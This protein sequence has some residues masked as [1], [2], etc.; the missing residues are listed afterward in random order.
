MPSGLL[1]CPIFSFNPFPRPKFPV[2]VNRMLLQRYVLREHL[3]PFLFS[4]AVIMFL[5]IVDLILHTMDLVL[6][7]A[8]QRLVIVELFFLNTAWMVALAVPM[9]V[10]VAT[11][12]AFGRLSADNEVTAIRSAGVGGLQ[13]LWPVLAAA[14]LLALGLVWFND[15]VLPEF[16][17]RARL[18]TSDIQRKRPT[19]VLA[20]REGTVIRDF[21]NLRFVFGGTDNQ[22]SELTDL[23]IY[24]YEK[25]TFPVTIVAARGEI[26]HE[27]GSD[28]AFLALYNGEIHRF[29]DSEPEVYISATF[30]KQVLRLGDAGRRLRRTTSEYRTDREMGIGR[31]QERVAEVE[32]ELLAMHASAGDRI[33]A[34][35]RPLLL[36]EPVAKVQRQTVQF[37]S[38]ARSD[39]TLSRHKK[40]YADRYRVEIHKKYSIPAACIAFVLVGVPLGV[41]VRGSG[42]GIGTG[43]SIG[44]FLIYWM[45]L[46]GGEKLADRGHLSPWLAMWA[47]NLIVAAAGI[48]LTGRVLF[49]R[50]L[51]SRRPA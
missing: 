7:V 14:T 32:E 35:V 5:L 20:G 38:Q 29:D 1:S 48:W 17:H 25:G 30:E 22:G 42:P 21:D 2:G 39:Q 10:L 16:N 28:E 31:M 43:I 47:P 45:C 11:L 3:F 34:F 44:F 26:V 40:R 33:D 4:F 19:A 23:V 9:A 49:D 27:S 12:L 6:K 18:L 36:G 41:R 50:H 15:R 46:I 8:D 13:L 51:K 37:L 24:R